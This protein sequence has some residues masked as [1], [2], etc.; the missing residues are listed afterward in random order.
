M[1]QVKE[2]QKSNTA[3]WG[4]KSL[5]IFFVIGWMILVHVLAFAGLLTVIFNILNYL[6][7]GVWE[8]QH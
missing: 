6:D 8:L 5:N 3:Y 1:S 7:A 4:T 2:K